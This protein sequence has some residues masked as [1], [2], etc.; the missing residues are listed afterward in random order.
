MM[1]DLLLALGGLG[2]FLLGMVIMTDGLK[3]LAGPALRRLLQRFTRSPT[4]GA[5]AGAAATA[6]IQSSSATIVTAIGF[7]GAGLMTFPQA[8]G[9]VFGA[10]IGTTV[11]G[12]LVAL[13]GFKLKL[14]TLVLPLLLVGV[15]LR[16]FTGRRLRLLGW[17][18]AGFSLLFVGIEA[19]QEGMA[20]FQGVVTPEDF[21]DDTLLGRLQLLGIGIAITLVTQSSSAGVATALVA[22]AAGTISLP[23]AAAMVIGMDLGTTCTAAL[24]AIGG[25]RAARQTAWSHVIYNILTALMAFFLLPLFA[26]LAMPWAAEASGNQQVA[27]VAF[28]SC[29]NLLGVVLILPFAGP[30][31]GL[32]VRLAPERADPLSRRLDER[33]LSDAAAACDAAQATLCDI[34]D[35]LEAFLMAALRPQRKGSRGSADRSEELEATGPALEK[36]EDFIQAIRIERGREPRLRQRL[37]AILHVLD[38]LQRLHARCGQSERLAQIPE[39]AR[40]RRLSGLLAAVLALEGRE[41][42]LDRLS[43]LYRRAQH[44]YRARIISAAVQGEIDGDTALL[45]L[46]AIR[47]LH[48]VSYHLWRVD[49]YRKQLAESQPDGALRPE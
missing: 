30:F 18:L 13:L 3:G 20:V 24:A 23:Q 36:A 10:N 48:R 33:L 45:R 5:M 47:W 41:D 9:I 21:P 14:G 25:T 40:L 1:A 43:R 37:E 8:L 38:H 39:D 35:A 6:L 22:L 26:Y 15:L 46:D 29:F 12:W 32:I 42:R 27:L 34:A 31:A 17:A 4:S 28:H 2:L 7:V 19:M 16:L 11:T 44:S 49:S